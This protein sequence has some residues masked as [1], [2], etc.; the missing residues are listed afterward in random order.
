MKK[1]PGNIHDEVISE[2]HSYTFETE[3]SKVGVINDGFL[4]NRMKNCA[5]IPSSAVQMFNQG[6]FKY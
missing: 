4:T 5:L 2:T 1:N 3:D 6:V